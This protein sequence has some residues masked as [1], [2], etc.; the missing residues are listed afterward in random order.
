MRIIKGRQTETLPLRSFFSP[1]HTREMWPLGRS[2]VLH[3]DREKAE[4]EENM[5]GLRASCWLEAAHLAPP[6]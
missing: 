3:S 5:A 4:E 6:G 1:A 2:E